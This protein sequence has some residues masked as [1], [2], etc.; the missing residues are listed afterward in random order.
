MF[1]NAPNRVST[2]S[3]T[4]NNQAVQSTHQHRTRHDILQDLTRKRQRS[5]SILSFQKASQ[6]VIR[7]VWNQRIES[8]TRTRSNSCLSPSDPI[9]SVCGARIDAVIER[10][11][12]SRL[13]IYGSGTTRLY[14][15]LTV[16]EKARSTSWGSVCCAVC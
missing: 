6:T 15:L 4:R 16:F 1:I 9:L 5:T 11:Y 8:G 14:I 3:K 10:V 13:D 2:S 12:D 7:I